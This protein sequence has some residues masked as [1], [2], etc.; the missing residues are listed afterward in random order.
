MNRV[1]K[2]LVPRSIKQQIKRDIEKAVAAAVPPPPAF[3][4]P[5]QEL[6]ALSAR[7]A[8]LEAALGQHHTILWREMGAAPPP[9]R[10]MQ[11]RTVGGYV[12]G[13]LESG[14]SILDDLEAVLKVAGTS[15]A[16]F[17]RM[18]DYGCGSGRTTRALKTR[19]PAAEVH[20]TDID[21]E[22]IAWLTRHCSRFGEFRL[23]PH[24][25]PTP[26]TDGFFDFIVGISVFTHLPEDMQFAWLKELRRITKPGGLLILTTSGKKNYVDLPPDLLRVVEE[27]GF[28]YVDGGYGQSISLPAFYQNTFHRPEYV[29]EHWSRFFEV[30]DIQET[31]MQNHQDTVLLRNSG[32]SG[33]S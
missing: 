18:L 17:P 26:Y 28:C 24:Q 21:P 6:R 33:P 14:Y 22:A 25:P 27:R 8:D 3:E 29:R 1:L 10:H 19:F 7:V 20:G 9:P 12:P 5:Q 23:A 32:G 31:R 4:T 13:F 16:S 11:V 2:N 30:L 15:L